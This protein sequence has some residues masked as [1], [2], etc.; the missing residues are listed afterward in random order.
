MVNCHL[1]GRVK[2]RSGS[3]TWQCFHKGLSEENTSPVRLAVLVIGDFGKRN[4]LC[5]QDHFRLVVIK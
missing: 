3:R 1:E 5:S 2:D 4:G